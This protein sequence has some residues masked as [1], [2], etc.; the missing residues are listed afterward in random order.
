MFPIGSP[1]V[2]DVSRAVLNVTE[3]QKMVEIE[4]KWLG[5]TKKCLDSNALV[6]PKN[7]GLASFWGLFLIVGVAGMTALIIYVVRFVRE[8]WSECDGD[9][10]VWRRIV[11]L[12][13]RFDNKDLS[14]HT[15]KKDAYGGDC[16]G[17]SPSHFSLL[18]SPRTNGPPSPVMSSPGLP[19]P[20]GARE[21]EL[22]LSQ[23]K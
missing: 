20:V 3:G 8:N 7:L 16:G 13:H 10:T 4:R 1:L 5:G 15:F 23:R 22:C 19:S 14:S 6:S 12:L 21:I 11:E 18:A 9:A 2:T 17:Q